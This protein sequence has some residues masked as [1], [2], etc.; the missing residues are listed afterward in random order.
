MFETTLEA[1]TLH[2]GDKRLGT[3]SAAALAHFAIGLLIV[4]LTA[5]I[6]PPVYVKD[7]PAHVVT[8]GPVDPIG[9]DNPTPQHPPPLKGTRPS[10]GAKH[11]VLPPVDPVSPPERIPETIPDASPGTDAGDE[12]VGTP[13]DP[14]GS[15]RGIPGTDTFGSGA[16]GG[17]GAA[18][19]GPL[20][21]TGDM[22][23]PVLLSKVEPAYPNAARLARLPGKVVVEAVIGLDGRVESAVVIS[24]TSTLFDSA[25]AQAVRQW[26]YKPALMNA[27]PVRVYFTV[28]VSFVLR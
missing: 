22:Q 6:V 14:N 12:H 5:L 11:L 9:I 2:D 4:A 28:V 13:G 8:I 3:L 10:G 25:A 20:I 7:P 24:S 27:Q 15:D 1:Q 16:G 23:R 26:R 21:L 17:D 18:N 19:T